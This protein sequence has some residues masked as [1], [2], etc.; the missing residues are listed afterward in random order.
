MK[1]LSITRLAT[2]IVCK[3]AT[4]AL[5]SAS[6]GKKAP[7]GLGTGGEGGEWG[8]GGSGV[9]SSSGAGSSDGGGPSC[10]PGGAACDA[11]SECC[12]QVC[13]NQVCT[14]CASIGQVCQNDCCGSLICYNGTCKSCADDGTS[15]TLASECCSNVCDEGVCAAGTTASSSSGSGGASNMLDCNG[16]FCNTSF[17]GA[18]CWNFS[19]ETGACV[20]GTTQT[21]NCVTETVPGG[22]ATRIECQTPA[23]CPAGTIC[24]GNLIEDASG[25]H[26]ESLT[27]QQTC[28]WPKRVLCDQQG[29][30]AP[31]CPVVMT[32][33]GPAQTTC[34]PSQ[35]LPPGY[36][37]CRP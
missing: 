10:K 7:L 8:S 23:H 29:E 14:A 31:G 16:T 26:Y 9:T 2:L 18:C 28:D 3:L 12:S 27:C 6:C 32:T 21:D 34:S 25:S 19:T 4:V 13:D 36:L 37:I 20:Q 24:C 11:F 30:Q 5:A 15:C 17:M 35:I 1:S 33:T 22:G